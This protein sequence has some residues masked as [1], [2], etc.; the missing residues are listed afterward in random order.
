LGNEDSFGESAEEVL[1]SLGFVHFGTGLGDS[2]NFSNHLAMMAAFVISIAIGD[3][4]IPGKLF[5]FIVR[6]APCIIA[7]FV[8]GTTTAFVVYRIS[9]P[10][11]AAEADVEVAIL[12]S[13]ASNQRT[14]AATTV[15][16][17]SIADHY[18]STMFA[19]QE[20]RATSA[21]FHKEQ[22][23]TQIEDEAAAHK[24]EELVVVVTFAATSCYSLDVTGRCLNTLKFN[25][26]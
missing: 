23:V 26:Y 10:I 7:A 11:K 24:Q 13:V 22:V 9:A 4:L 17:T 18:Y 15:T 14:I 19:Y 2:D 25:C 20:D 3:T 12:A 6:F 21:G 5:E 1:N 8:N 16:A